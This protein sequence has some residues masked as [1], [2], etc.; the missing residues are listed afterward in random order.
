M[1]YLFD[2]WCRDP[3]PMLFG[4]FLDQLYRA[5][6]DHTPTSPIEQELAD[7]YRECHRRIRGGERFAVCYADLDSFKEYN[8]QH[9]P[10]K[11]KKVVSMLSQILHDVVGSKCPKDGFVAHVG[12]DD[13]VLLVAASKFAEVCGEACDAFD[14]QI[15]RQYEAQE[16]ATIASS[17][18]DI[19]SQTPPV[20]R[21][22]LSIGVVT[23]E[24]RDFLHF[25]QI[26]ELALEMKRY[27]KTVAGS[28]FVVDRRWEP[29]PPPM[30]EGDSEEQP[31]P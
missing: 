2:A 13:F 15:A 1:Q 7:L 14:N 31:S 16:R 24:E 4:E 19:D 6:E 3:R 21:L 10:A 9:G 5:W 17:G 8:D 25:A 27:A 18:K 28:V 30:P 23:N 20:D 12:G 22:A 29:G 26:T 11:G